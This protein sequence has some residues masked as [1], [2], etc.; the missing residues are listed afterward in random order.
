MREEHL[1]SAAFRRGAHKIAGR[2][3]DK[4]RGVFNSL[5]RLSP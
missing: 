4:A 5:L 2:L 1:V 3:M